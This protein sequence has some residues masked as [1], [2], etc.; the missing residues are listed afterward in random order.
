[1]RLEPRGRRLAHI[2]SSLGLVLAGL[3]QH[4]SRLANKQ[5]ESGANKQDSNNNFYLLDCILFVAECDFLLK[6]FTMM[7]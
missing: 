1:M 7:L 6:K 5:P 3:K 2:F 4:K